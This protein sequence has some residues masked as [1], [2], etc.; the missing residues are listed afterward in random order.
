M[1]QDIL[2]R[3]VN[4]VRSCPATASRAGHDAQMMARLRPAGVI[5]VPSVGGLSHN[6]RE[7][8]RPEHLAAGAV[9]LDAVLRLAG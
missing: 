8:T 5:L 4:A 7:E 3:D 2:P 9:L 1:R 6:L